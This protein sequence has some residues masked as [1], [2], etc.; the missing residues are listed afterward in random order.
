MKKY[1]FFGLLSRGFIVTLLF[2][3][4]TDLKSQ[5]DV[6]DL[7]Q[8]T[9]YGNC[10]TTPD[11]EITKDRISCDD[12]TTV[13][14]RNKRGY[15]SM[16]QTGSDWQYKFSGVDVDICTSA[17]NDSE[18]RVQIMFRINGIQSAVRKWSFLLQKTTFTFPIVR[19]YQGANW[20]PVSGVLVSGKWYRYEKEDNTTPFDS[21]VIISP[22]DN[23]YDEEVFFMNSFFLPTCPLPS[24]AGA[25]TGFASV[26]QGQTNVNYSIS[27]ICNATSYVWS[28]PSGASITAGANTDSITVSFSTSATSGVITVY[29]ANTCGNGTVSS[30]F[31]VTVNPYNTIDLLS[32]AGTDGQTVCIN[33]A[34]ANITYSTTGATGATVAGLPAGV[35]GSWAGNV[36]TISGIPTA[37]GTFNYNITLTGG[38]G[39]VTKGGT[40]NVTPAN[41]ITL[42]SA[43]GTDNQTRCINTAIAN[44]TYSTTRATGATV[45]GLPTGV[46]GSWAGNVVTISGTPTTTT[47][48]PFG[49]TVTLTGGCGTETTNGTITVNP[50]NTI[51][52]T[53]ATVTKTQCVKINGAIIDITY[54]TTGA[55]GA[56]VTG[57]PAGVTGSWTGNTVTISGIPT[58]TG[59]FN[60]NITLTGGCGTAISVGTITVA[61][62]VATTLPEV[63]CLYDLSWSMNRDFYD[64]STS[65]PFAI[66][67]Y[68]ARNALSAF[69]DLLYSNEPCQSALGVA[70]FPDSPQVG[71]D[72]GT[73]EISQFLDNLY[74]NYLTGPSG[75]IQSLIADGNSTPLLE[76]VN[77][78]IGLFNTTNANKTIVLLTDG[79]QNCPY[80]GISSIIT[81][82]NTSLKNAGIKLFTIGFGDYGIVPDDILEQLVNG[83]GGRH[84]NIRTSESKLTPPYDPDD[85]SSLVTWNAGTALNAV[86]NNIIKVLLGLGISDDPLDIINQGEVKQF[87][88]PITIFDEKV[89]FFVSWVTPQENYLNIKL[90]TPAGTELSLDQGGINIIHRNNHTIITLYDAL[91]SQPGMT[92]IWKLKIDGTALGNPSEFYQHTV[93][94]TSKKL[95]LKTWFDKEKYLTGEKIKIYAELLLEEKPLAGLNK[96]IIMGTS[97][98]MNPGNWLV[99][100][101]LDA[102][103][104]EK[105]K[106]KQLEEYLKV[107]S[108]QHLIENLNREARE[109]YLNSQTNNFLKN[110]DPIE[111]RI[112]ALRD[113]YHLLPPGDVKI[114]G[115][116]FNDNGKNG[117]QKAGDGIYTAVYVPKLEGTYSFNISFSDSSHGEKILRESHMQTFINSGSKLKF[118]I[119]NIKFI[120]K[121]T[122]GEKLYDITFTLKDKYGNIPMPYALADLNLSIGKGLLVGV[123]T[124]N[125]NGTFTQR[126]SLPSGVRLRTVIL[127][128][129]SGELSGSRKI[130]TGTVK[131][132]L[133]AIALI[134]AG[135]IFLLAGK[136]KKKRTDQL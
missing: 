77:H 67:L 78:A 43:A 125:M 119:R 70:R 27:D 106:Q 72:A 120:D 87:D 123:I 1:T 64:N 79:R 104:I 129:S 122:T 21:I 126:I 108:A 99:S 35:T 36:V 56:T 48:S 45:S 118:T 38:C 88:I 11:L 61:D 98:E 32:A 100:R 44:I 101:K 58:A 133:P 93:L 116:A 47:G 130:A 51:T 89:C 40:I 86:F 23:R 42:S 37:S 134:L 73:V 110:I 66:K 7:Y 80:S 14:I 109:E 124:D 114:K 84:Y 31:T 34:I 82:T 29:G 90:L 107:I 15:R 39:T 103:M 81:T 91:L 131:I 127:S 8:G 65:D 63:I 74:D 53:S 135:A 25:I 57:L 115:L 2:F 102:Q 10:M 69:V 13:I 18:G 16:S 121:T 46:T 92:G 112:H 19:Y 105:A 22:L 128:F 60:Y 71:C 33:T 17:P 94:N 96:T 26:C 97:P 30:N 20:Y 52:L 136:K 28:L 9:G 117:D 3:S 54:S 4:V 83:T 62:V 12:D 85:P 132:I 111:V 76:G 55:T 68:H 95:D 75:R 59:I 41:S 113:E 49:Y 6:L 50:D 24:A 5:V